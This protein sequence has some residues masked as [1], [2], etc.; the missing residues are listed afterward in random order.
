MVLVPP[1]AWGQFPARMR[2]VSAA[3]VCSPRLTCQRVTEAGDRLARLHS[4]PSGRIGS[5]RRRAARL[6][7]PARR[8]R[9]HIE[10]STPCA[11]SDS[12]M[13]GAPETVLPYLAD[14][15]AP[16]EPDE[17]DHQERNAER[18]AFLLTLGVWEVIPVEAFESREARG[19]ERFPWT[20][21]EQDDRT[22]RVAAAG[23][24]QFGRYLWAGAEH[25]NVWVAEDF[26]FRWSLAEAA[27]REPAKTSE[28]LSLGASLYSRLDCVAAFCPGCRSGGVSHV[29]AVPE[30]RGRQLPEHRS[31]SSYRRP[32]GSRR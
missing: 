22:Q 31:R 11:P 26:R 15:V 16:D 32:H 8:E 28:L 7:A 4:A 27:A 13:I 1:G 2:I 19:R 3:D 25:Q 21:P 5:R 6:P 14:H 23:G 29:S 17:A 9:T 24:W 10:H 30:L 20:G 18:H 12:A